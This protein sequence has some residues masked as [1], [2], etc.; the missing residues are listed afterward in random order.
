MQTA[1]EVNPRNL[2]Q[3][4]IVKALDYVESN[5]SEI[6]EL[7]N[8]YFD[9]TFMSIRRITEDRDFPDPAFERRLAQDFYQQRG[10]QDSSPAI[11]LTSLMYAFEIPCIEYLLD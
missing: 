4:D 10:I 11:K 2:T 7:G 5:F 3:S 1:V 9:E 6:G 8:L